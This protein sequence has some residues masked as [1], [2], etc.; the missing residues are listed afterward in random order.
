MRPHQDLPAAYLRSCE[1][2]FNGLRRASKKQVDKQSSSAY[3][4]NSKK[5]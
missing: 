4:G 3:I 1:K 2:F 5:G